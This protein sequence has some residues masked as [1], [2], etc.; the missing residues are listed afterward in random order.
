MMEAFSG[1]KCDGKS[2]PQFSGKKSQPSPLTKAGSFTE[3]NEHEQ[4]Q[5]LEKA[6]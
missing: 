2:A 1:H 6:G 3:C 4:E 5:L